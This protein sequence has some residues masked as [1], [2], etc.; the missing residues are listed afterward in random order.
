MVGA[1]AGIVFGLSS[2][3]AWGAGDFIGGYVSRRVNPAIV[4]LVS[5]LAGLVMLFAAA[6]AVAEPFPVRRDLFYGAAG[7]L[8]GV[9]GLGALYRGLAEHKM[10]T[11]APLSALMTAALPIVA[12]TILEGFP[13]PAQL[14]GIL[15][16]VPAIYW[17]SR[18]E[19]STGLLKHLT[20]DVL[21][22]PLVAGL[23]FGSFFILLDQV[24]TGV[25]YWPIV[26]ARAASVLA[27]V[28][29]L[30]VT[31]TA[32]AR[33]QTGSDAQG[34]APV[35]PE[36]RKEVTR[37]PGAHDGVPLEPGTNKGLSL[38][39]GTH[40]GVPLLL[41]V[42][43]IFDAGGNVFFAL[44]TQAGRLDIA[45]V[46]ASL[47]PAGTVFLAWLVLKERLSRTQ[48]LGVVAALVAVVL[49]SI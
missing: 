49:F 14:A 8:A 36:I 17:V 19:D 16:A 35:E 13:A 34:G 40:K 31:R 1:A 42:G 6:L 43:G 5:Q 41:L 29:W 22:Y 12:G 2:A 11:I 46:L 39:P 9:I 33:V 28:G 10:G 44:A 23:G 24:S 37:G 30:I 25:V 45:S 27:V 20:W 7:G 4:I 38:E 18:E 47:F 32:R 48:L 26:A 15:V 21:K 3:L